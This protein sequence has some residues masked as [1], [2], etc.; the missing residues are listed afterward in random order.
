MPKKLTPAQFFETMPIEQAWFAK[1]MKLSRQFFSVIIKENP[2]S[3]RRLVELKK[4]IKQ[5]AKELDNIDITTKVYVGRKYNWK[6][7]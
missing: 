2:M 3:D 4:L 6:K 7:K 5:L 1:R